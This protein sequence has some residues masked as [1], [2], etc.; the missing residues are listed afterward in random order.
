[1][2]ELKFVNENLDINIGDVFKHKADGRRMVVIDFYKSSKHADPNVR[3]KNSPVCRFYN[4]TKEKYEIQTFIY[5]ELTK[6]E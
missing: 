6:D 2:S 4:E 3:D 5:A 1:M